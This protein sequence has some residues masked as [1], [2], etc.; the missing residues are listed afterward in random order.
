MACSLFQQLSPSFS[1]RE[2]KLETSEILSLKSLLVL[3]GINQSFPFRYIPGRQWQG[4][5]IASQGPSSQVF[6]EQ[7]E[8]D[9]QELWRGRAQGQGTEGR[10]LHLS[11]EPRG[12][13]FQKR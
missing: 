7:M 10:N 6:W 1:P 5:P 4:D 11:W 3:L 8:L 2:N 9:G 12:S 13:A